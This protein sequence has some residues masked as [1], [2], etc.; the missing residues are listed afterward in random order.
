MSERSNEHD[1]KSC[2]VK[3]SAGSN[4]VLCARWSDS[5]FT[6]RNFKRNCNSEF[7][8]GRSIFPASTFVLWEPYI[9]NRPF[10]KLLRNCWPIGRSFFY[11]HFDIRLVGALL[12]LHFY[13][14]QF[15]KKLQQ[16]VYNQSLHFS[17]FDIRLVG[18]LY[19]KS[20]FCQITA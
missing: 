17:H 9:I 8:I 6:H 14:P 4:P 10:V 15:Q 19:Y 1:W 11:S 16:W 3:A 18:A 12:I 7:I 2:D 5:I 20:P 13:S